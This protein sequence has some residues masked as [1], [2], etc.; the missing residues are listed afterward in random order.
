MSKNYVSADYPGYRG[1]KTN[2]KNTKSKSGHIFVI[3]NGLN[4]QFNVS[5]KSQ[6]LL[7]VKNSLGRENT[8]G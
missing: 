3:K 1:S 5:T 2:P 7:H 8:C 6:L 4:V